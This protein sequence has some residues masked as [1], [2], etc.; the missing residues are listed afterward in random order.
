MQESA[1]STFFGQ[2]LQ[3]KATLKG[4]G[5]DEAIDGGEGGVASLQQRL[6]ALQELTDEERGVAVREKRLSGLV[7][8][9]P[10]SQQTSTT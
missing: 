6:S 8:L 4:T 2:Q 10:L 3:K 7:S 9:R 1:D 5:G